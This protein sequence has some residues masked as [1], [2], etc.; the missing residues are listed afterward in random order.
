LE[1]VV[2]E[3]YGVDFFACVALDDLRRE[4]ASLCKLHFVQDTDLLAH[5]LDGCQT[6][7]LFFSACGDRIGKTAAE[8]IAS[9]AADGNDVDVLSRFGFEKAVRRLYHVGVEGSS[10]ALVSADHNQQDGFLFAP[11]EQRMARLTGDGIVDLC[12]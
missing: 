10:E 7:V 6:L 9:L 3:I 12:A 8:H 5:N 4:I 11:L 2:N 1:L